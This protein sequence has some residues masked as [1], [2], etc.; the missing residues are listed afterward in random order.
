MVKSL[1]NIASRVLLVYFMV[2]PILFGAHALLHQHHNFSNHEAGI[3]VTQITD[4]LLCDLYH[5]QN[6]TITSSEIAVEVIPTDTLYQVT[7]TNPA[8]SAEETRHLRGPPTA[9]S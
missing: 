6:A 9:I 7:F 3:S 1:V 4:C 2:L 8:I 5:A